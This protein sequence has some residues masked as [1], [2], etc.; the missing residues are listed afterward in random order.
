MRTTSKKLI[1]SLTSALYFLM[2]AAPLYADDIEIFTGMNA[3]AITA[4]PNVLFI[5][6]TSGSMNSNVTVTTGVYDPAT[7]YAGNCAANHYYWSQSGTAPACGTRYYIEATSFYCNDASTALGTGGAGYYTGRFARYRNLSTDRWWTLYY[8]DVT[9]RVECEADYGVDGDGVDTNKLYPANQ[10]NGGPW[11][12]NSSNAISWASTGSSYTFYSS[13]Y[14]NWLNS[15]GVSTTMSRLAIVQDVLKNII[16]STSGINA[17]LMRF[18][19]KCCW[20]NVGGYFVEPMQEINATT[21]PT[22][23]TTIDNLT[24]GGYTPL[25][26]TLYEAMLFFQGKPVYFGTKTD[27]GTNVAGVLKPSNTA[28][29]KSPIEFQCQKNFVVVLTD[30]DPT[31]DD[32]ADTLINGMTGFSTLTGGCGYSAD[33]CLDEVAQ[34][35]YDTDQSNLPG[36]QNIIT[37]TIGFGG[38]IGNLTLLMDTARKGGSS[39][40][41]V[42]PSVGFFT[43]DSVTGLTDAFTS[44][45]TSIN[46][47]NT[48]FVSPAVSVN[49][50]NR[51]THRSDLYF[52]L[53]LP[54][55]KYR[56]PGNLKKYKLTRKITGDPNSEL[57]IV[58]AVIQNQSAVDTAT[59]FFKSGARSFWSSVVDGADVTLGGA[60]ER[61][62]TANRR[63]YTFTGADS[64]ITPPQTGAIMLNN[65]NNKLHE[66]NPVLVATGTSEDATANT[67]LGLPTTT[68]DADRTT[69]IQWARGVDVLDEDTD[70][71]TTDYRQSMGDPLHSE[72]QL[73]NYKGTSD[74]DADITLYMT[75]N[76]G[77]LHA[78]NASDG[79]PSTTD[80]NELFAFMPKELLPNLNILK[81]NTTTATRT[82]GLD[83]PMTIWHDDLNNDLLVLNPDDTVQ[84]SNGKDEHVYLYFG[85][86]RGGN[87]YYALDVTNRNSPKLKWKIEGGVPGDFEELGQSWSKMT[88]AKIKF[89]GAEKDVLIFGGGYDTSVDNATLPADDSTGR[90]IFI[91]DAETGQRLWWASITGSGA[92][93]E[94]AEMKNSIAANLTVFDSTGDGYIDRIYAADL[95]ARIW[96][97]DLKDS[98]AGMLA[99]GGVFADLN[100]TAINATAAAANNRHFYYAPDVSYVR[101]GSQEYFTIAIGSGFRAHP[102][103]TS[104]EDRFYVLRD[105]NVRGP[106]EDSNG[107]A[108]YTTI[109]ENDLYDTTGNI[110]GEG[111][112]TQVDAARQSLNTNQGWYIKLNEMDGS[113]IGEKIIGESVTFNGILIFSS[114]TPTNSQTNS[115]SA[116]GASAAWAINLIDGQPVFNFDTSNPDLTRSD[117]KGTLN[118]QGLP[119]S[120]AIVFPEDGGDVT[121]LFGTLNL[122]NA[123]DGMGNK[124]LKPTNYYEMD[125]WNIR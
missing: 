124:K 30:G 68:S 104:I 66:S 34:Y 6:D 61:L 23:K 8:R 10:N 77:F 75:T 26:E 54:T 19:N 125:Y 1:L 37:Y 84:S 82:Y 69:L 74:A 106:A 80:G 39:G 14:I 28:E 94:L 31:Y 117:R 32:D 100:G 51:L 21:R 18:D 20:D 48:T 55:D 24:A 58:D 105:T 76:E 15:P 9:S 114:F 85:M 52:A 72:P 65:T 46:Q 53:F 109:T 4:L 120:P 78:I 41:N 93:L 86:R 87:N 33:D 73:I 25:A 60:A 113:F 2:S 108:I 103:D 116:K 121:A 16:D 110:I 43:A 47:I 7:T 71:S 79:N 35:L 38:G 119:P 97:F 63:I 5:I 17:A 36:T 107:N 112:Q 56:W 12:S 101:Q 11:R 91:V 59:G 102:L 92:D 96:R 83:G 62:P 64:S 118:L 13:N 122:N 70:G 111:T 27:P 99:T 22:F 89:A 123:G 90:A 40:G 115:C 3:N 42:D 88:Y 29:Y 67:L 57:I 45:M 50:F 44:I 49:A 81:G 98:T 95:A